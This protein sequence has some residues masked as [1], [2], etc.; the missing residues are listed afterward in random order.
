MAI[1]WDDEQHDIT[2]ESEAVTK[3][4]EEVMPGPNGEEVTAPKPDQLRAQLEAEIAQMRRNQLA[5]RY[6]FVGV[7]FDDNP[8]G[9]ADMD[10]GSKTGDEWMG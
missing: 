2:A 6:S 8:T 4:G 1:E 3:T 5:A 9:H 10:T 7:D